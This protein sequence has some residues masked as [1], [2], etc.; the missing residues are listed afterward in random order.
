MKILFWL[1][2][3]GDTAALLLLFVLGLAAA[4][5]SR[6]SPFTVAAYMLVVPALVLG[7]AVLLF[8]RSSSALGRSVAV[9]LAG[10]PLLIVLVQ[11]ALTTIEIRQSVN[12]AGDIVYFRPGPLR[13]IAEAIPRNDTVTIARLVPTVDVNT[14]GFSNATL[15]GRALHQLKTMPT[16]HGTIRILLDAGADPNLV[17]DDLPL[18]IAIQQSEHAGT[19]PVRLLLKAGAKPNTI[20]TFGT[21]V[22]FMASGITVPL[23][24]LTLVLDNGADLK[25]TDRDGRTILFQA[26]NSSNW[27]AV[28]LLLERGADYKVGKT[29]NG[30]SFGEMVQ[31]Y[32]RTFGDTAGVAEVLEYLKRQ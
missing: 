32:A 17:A 30:E 21:P 22:F 15:L 8:M 3:A 28:R 11:R 4:P 25:L 13:E 24:V 5:S 23:E 7:A 9:L 31:S 18:E 16:E 6:T 1:L 27:K 12:D 29:L 10:A 20:G 14:R 26:A 2:V 19:E